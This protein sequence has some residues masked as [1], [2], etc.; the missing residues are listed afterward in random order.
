MILPRPK[1]IIAHRGAPELARENTLES[2]AIAVE[3]GAHMIEFD[4]R[5]T[6]DGSIVVHHDPYISFQGVN[7]DI[8]RITHKELNSIAGKKSYAVPTLT[9]VLQM[10][11]GKTTFDI[12]IKESGYEEEITE[13]VDKFLKKQEYIFTSFNVSVTSRLKHLSGENK[14]GLLVENSELLMEYSSAEADLFCPSKNLYTSH[15]DFFT[16]VHKRGLLIAVWTVNSDKLL[17]TLIS[18]PCVDAII[19]NRCRQAL[20]LL[21][22]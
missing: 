5:K 16:A 3:S 21:D 17:E 18:D 4:L 7:Y 15:K 19:T 2:F 22:N 14:V 11:S 12:E 8:A 10:F 13:I 9:D 20:R 6:V 1:T